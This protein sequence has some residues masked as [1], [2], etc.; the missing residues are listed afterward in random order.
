[1]GSP[2]KERATVRGPWTAPVLSVPRP[3]TSEPTAPSDRKWDLLLVCVAGYLL[4]AV[5]RVHQLFPFLDL[6]RPA[7]LTGALAVLLY[8][9]DSRPERR[10]SH[11]AA[12]TTKYLLALLFWM[13]LSIPGSLSPGTSFE[14]VFGNLVKTVAM[15]LVAVGTLRGIRDVERLAATYLV[16][17]FVYAT[18]VIARFDLGAGPDWRLGHLYYYDANDLATFLVTAVPIG[19]YFLVNVRRPLVR[20]LT[21]IAL[22][23]L[24]VAFVRTGSRGGFIAL[25]AV[26][27]FIVVRYSAIPLRRRVGA[28]LLV[29]VV[30]VGAASDQYWEQ[31]GTITSD[32]DYNRTDERGRMQIWS[33]GID[34]MLQN[35]L[36]GVGPGNFPAAEGTLSPFAQRR[37]FG[38][39]VRWSAAHNSFIQVG[40]ETGVIGLALVVALL[41]SAFVALHR[42]RP[43]EGSSAGPSDRRTQLAQVLTASLVGFVVGAFFL[44]LA[45]AEILYT[46]VALAVGLQ[47]VTAEPGP[48]R[49]PVGIRG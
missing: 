42:S 26:A 38:V 5:G 9:C 23:V 1:M 31:M 15:Y 28:T 27:G 19:L 13:M 2:V 47:K 12:P 22:A 36:F 45:Y 16:A 44:S 39:G 20:V 6:V 43:R 46:L 4:T 17:A 32:A 34:Y 7:M 48:G 35:P 10:A 14:M 21:A 24:A 11:L 33:R 8:L 18:V 29:A 3:A 40:A 25:A 41:A 37:Q 49:R 30:V